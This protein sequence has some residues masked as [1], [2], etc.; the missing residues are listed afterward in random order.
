[1][2]N[3]GELQ[4]QLSGQAPLQL[5]HWRINQLF[6]FLGSLP[7]PTHFVRKLH[8][9]EELC[10][11]EGPIQ[12]SLSTSY[13]SLLDLH[14]TEDPPFLAKWERDL[15]V[16]FTEPQKERILFF[17]QKSSMCSKYQETAYKIVTRWYRTPSVLAKI[18]PLQTDRCWR[19]NLHPG[20]L[21]HIFWDCPVL[22]TFWQPVL[23]LV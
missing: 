12:R 17:A 13:K 4:V 7:K 16:T 21:L 6:H 19:C 15:Q 11:G 14:A 22:K 10:L 23:K 5:D 3:Y 20:T 1:M 8:S 9:F 18:F 2:A